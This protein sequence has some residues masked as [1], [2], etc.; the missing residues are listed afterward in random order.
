MINIWIYSG[1][2]ESLYICFLSN[3]FHELF[4]SHPLSTSPKDFLPPSTSIPLY[5]FM[6]L[7]FI[8]P[9]RCTFVVLLSPTSLRS[10][11]LV[12]W[13]SF[14]GEWDGRGRCSPVKSSGL[15]M[16]VEGEKE[17]QSCGLWTTDN[18]TLA[19]QHVRNFSV[20]SEGCSQI[21]MSLKVLTNKY[22]TFLVNNC[23][24]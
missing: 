18:L 21:E 4:T 3:F 16:F 22:S 20:I 15:R 24:I 6:L 1:F 10:L 23:S 5:F 7:F 12:T 14:E 11:C 8:W 17:T 19:F 13:V 9:P 2:F